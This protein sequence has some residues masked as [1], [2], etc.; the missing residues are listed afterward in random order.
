MKPSSPFFRHVAG[1]SC[2]RPF[3]RH[4]AGSLLLTLALSAAPPEKAEKYHAAL[5][6]RP[7]NPTLFDRF[8]NAWIDE[9][10]LES[11]EAYLIAE[12]GK[13][14]GPD[15][16][17]LARYHLRRGNT[18]AALE[19]L[20]KAITALPDDPTLPMERGKILLTDLNF[21]AARQDFT[22]A[23]NGPDPALALEASRLIG[24]SFLRENKPK[25]A[26]AT[27]D[28]LLAAHPNDE[29]LLEDLTESAAAGGQTDQAL[30]YVR[31]LIEI[32]KDPY[33][34]A[35]RKL[36]E[37]E[38]L[39]QAG[40]S[41]EA[42]AT[43]AA[44]LAETGEGSWLESEIL[45]RFEK[46]FRKQDRLVDLLTEL[47]KLAEAHPRRLLIHRQLAKMEAAN[48]D[49]DSAIGRFRV[50]LQRSPGDAPLR[51]E[52]I[53]L[54]IDG[55]RLEEAVEELEKMIALTPD[56]PELHLRMAD[57][58][59]AQDDAPATL[60][61]LGKARENFPQDE[62]STIR[63][64]GLMFRY[65]LGKEGEALLE[66]LLPSIPAAEALATE[67]AATKRKPEALE[68]L[69]A[70]AENPDP[71]IPQPE[72]LLRL[73]SA[74]ATLG[75]PE[76]T[77]TILEKHLPNF[78]KDPRYLTAF[79]RSAI[80]SEKSEDAVSHA[81]TLVRSSGSPAEIS[82]NT[83]LATR[84]LEAAQKTTET[85]TALAAKD[86]RTIAETCLLASLAAAEKD[87]EAVTAP[88]RKN[89]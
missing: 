1:A 27:W 79:V 22:K 56:N 32:S 9:Q 28:A 26:I 30:I 82:E 3:F 71:A 45:A 18:P 60:A 81:I 72:T 44:T 80:T 19:A 6:K 13:N 24:K 70:A 55:D 53:R 16:A 21:E 8:Y 66:S 4:L 7:E 57:I 68:L 35:L 61:A 83:R 38:I 59:F 88:F 47:K 17:I 36:R 65:D 54:L 23:A 87:H 33:K 14:G 73:T 86:D 77:H 37:G 42:T 39:A 43:Y 20:G 29:E 64:A 67:Y 78:P 50:V 15:L 74:I 76:I 51:E 89:R 5:L 75:S 52:F 34:K 41:D 62:P 48:G 49:M 2:T 63:I 25:E 58:R 11:L 31:N 12:A 10:P 85:R 84:L 46:V 40:K 69:Q